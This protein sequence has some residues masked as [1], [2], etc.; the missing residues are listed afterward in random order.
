MK[1]YLRPNHFVHR[2]NFNIKDEGQNN[3]FKIRGKFFLGFRELVMKDWNNQVLFKIHNTLG[4]LS[5]KPFL[6][7]DDKGQVIATVK[8]VKKQFTIIV[9]DKEYTLKGALDTDDL[10]LMHETQVL[11][12]LS[13]KIFDFGETIEIDVQADKH[14]LMHLFIVL[15]VAQMGYVKKKDSH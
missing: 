9:G 5:T 11:V 7:S 14:P 4:L 13:K 1:F 8:R 15:S 2:K 10:T 12:S 3:I 6:I